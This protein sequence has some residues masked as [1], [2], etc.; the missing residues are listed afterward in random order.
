MRSILGR[1]SINLV[2]T[3]NDNR[4]YLTGGL[5]YV[6]FHSEQAFTVPSWIL[7]VQSKIISTRC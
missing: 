6:T 2:K 5:H 4:H 7:S 1:N 3:D